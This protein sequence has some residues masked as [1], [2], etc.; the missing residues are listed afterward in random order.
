MT[1]TVFGSSISSLIM[2]LV[3]L[4]SSFLSNRTLGNVGPLILATDFSNKSSARTL[5]FCGPACS[6]EGNVEDE[7]QMLQNQITVNGLK[8]GWKFIFSCAVLFHFERIFASLVFSCICLQTVTQ[9]NC[10]KSIQNVENI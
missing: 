9:N 6:G 2:F 10:P 5:I 4:W 1:S 7:K 3:L 8:G